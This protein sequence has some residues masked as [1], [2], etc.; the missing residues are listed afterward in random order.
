MCGINKAL[1]VLDKYVSLHSLPLGNLNEKEYSNI[2]MSMS[3]SKVSTA[4]IVLLFGI[5]GLM[6]GFL[7]I[8]LLDTVFH[9]TK[10]AAFLDSWHILMFIAL[11]GISF[12]LIPLMKTCSG[13]SPLGK[14][15]AIW[16]SVAGLT[17]LSMSILTAIIHHFSSSIPDWFIPTGLMLIPIIPGAVTAVTAKGTRIWS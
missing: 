9:T 8:G 6:A 3:S 13:S 12:S 14:F 15:L 11:F 16:I 1:D 17:G 10:P 2:V 7:S 5:V 4:F